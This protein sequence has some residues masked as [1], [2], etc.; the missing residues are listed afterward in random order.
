MFFAIWTHHIYDSTH[1]DASL[2]STFMETIFH[3]MHFIKVSAKLLPPCFSTDGLSWLF[4][5]GL[6][7]Q[8][9]CQD[10]R[11]MLICAFV[12][13]YFYSL[14]PMGRCCIVSLYREGQGHC[15]YTRQGK[16]QIETDNTWAACMHLSLRVRMRIVCIRF[17]WQQILVT[18]RLTLGNSNSLCL[19]KRR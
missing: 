17:C 19:T 2:E 10:N 14:L 6:L 1:D 7:P 4:L 12:K 5:S 11:C 18:A 3:Y 8:S 16:M 15:G 9:G 13:Q